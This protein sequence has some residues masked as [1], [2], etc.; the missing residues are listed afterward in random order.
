[1]HH[2]QAMIDMSQI[3]LNHLIHVRSWNSCLLCKLG[4]FMSNNVIYVKSCNSCQIVSFMSNHV[5]LVKS[6]H[7]CQIMSLM[8][9]YVIHVKSCHPVCQH[10]RSLVNWCVI[11]V[12][13]NNVGGKSG[14]GHQVF[15]RPS[16]DSFAVGRWPFKPFTGKRIHTLNCTPNRT[17]R[18]SLIHYINYNSIVMP[19]NRTILCTRLSVR[20]DI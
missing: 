9:D 10:S 5:I 2:V 8:S 18:L 15:S 6:C 19:R 12:N 11:G 17:Y 3:I 4:Q 16:A 20:Y 13:F 14:W 1:M 7:S